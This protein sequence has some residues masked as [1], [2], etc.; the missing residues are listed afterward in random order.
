[1]TRRRP[2]P[3]EPTGAGLRVALPWLARLADYMDPAGSVGQAWGPRELVPDFVPE[4]LTS[5]R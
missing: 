3:V 5:T 1:M 2:L 4:Y